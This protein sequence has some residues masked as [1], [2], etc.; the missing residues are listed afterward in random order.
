MFEFVTWFIWLGLFSLLQRRLC[1]SYP[2]IRSACRI[3]FAATV[4]VAVLPGIWILFHLPRHAPDVLVQLNHY[5][6]IGVY[7]QTS[8]RAL[9]QL[10]WLALAPVSL[11]IT[12]SNSTFLMNKERQLIAIMSSLPQVLGGRE[13]RPPK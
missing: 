7:A 4:V 6:G 8:I 2:G 3:G 11:G 10:K 5:F 1:R 12:A 13:D 9:M